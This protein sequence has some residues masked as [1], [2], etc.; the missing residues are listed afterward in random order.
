MATLRKELSIKGLLEL[1]HNKFSSVKEINN[2]R[3][4][5]ISSVDCL[6]SGLALFSL[7]FPSLLKFDT[8]KA[9]DKTSVHNL[10]KLFKINIPISDTQVRTRLDDLDPLEIRKTFKSILA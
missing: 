10:K 3:S 6:M 9:E 7:K 2:G 5:K 1:V 8:S 4:N